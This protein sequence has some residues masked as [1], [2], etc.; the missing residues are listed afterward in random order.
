[1]ECEAARGLRK[2]IA[3][4]EMRRPGVVRTRLGSRGDYWS[5]VA[6]VASMALSEPLASATRCAT[7]R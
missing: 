3:R 4:A 6:I 5:C 7:V 1:M 2:N